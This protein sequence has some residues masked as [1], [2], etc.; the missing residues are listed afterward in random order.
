MSASWDE[1]SKCPR[2]GAYTGKVIQRK[3]VRGGGQLVTLVCPEDNCAY[4]D[5][6]WIVQVRPD[7]TIPDAVAPSQ[8]E[9]QFISSPVA[10]QRKKAILNALEEQVAAEQ[11]TGSEA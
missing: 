4:H 10:A 6:G 8:R 7:G 3:P 9:K 11:R 2:D 5:M 1:A